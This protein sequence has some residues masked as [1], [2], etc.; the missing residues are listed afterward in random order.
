ME[1]TA[2]IEGAIEAVMVPMAALIEAAA[3]AVGAGAV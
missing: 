3:T 1:V 2:D